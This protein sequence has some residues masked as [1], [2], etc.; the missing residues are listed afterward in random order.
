MQ[1]EIIMAIQIHPHARERMKER[2][3]SEDEL[4]RTVD[5]G[6]RFSAKFGRIGFRRNFSFDEVWRGKKYNTNQIEV[7]ATEEEQDLIIVTVIV[8]YF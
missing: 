1:G 2:G 3:A 4:I 7:F 8:R 5:T 6:E